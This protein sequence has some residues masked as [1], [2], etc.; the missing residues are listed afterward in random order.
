MSKVLKWLDNYWYHYKWQ[1]LIVIFVLVV[2]VIC[3]GQM[4]TRTTAD[5]YILYGGPAQLTANEIHE[6][7]LAIQLMMQQDYN[8]DGEK[9]AELIY[10]LL[11]TDQQRKDALSEAEAQSE[12]LIINAKN[13][14]DNQNAFA[15]QLAVGDAAICF[16]DP[17]WY[18]TARENNAFVP[19]ATLLGK[20]PENAQD[21]Y[22]ILLCDLPF[23]Q[24]FSA[25]SVFPPDTLVAVRAESAVNSSIGSDKKARLYEQQLEMFR[26]MVSF[27]VEN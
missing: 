26:S 18:Q 7:D 4:V 3:I 1:T 17:A 20:T 2:A 15:T 9:S 16:L 10:Y 22:S 19:L 5:V 25:F 14:T 12:P 13:L 24:Y 21:E 6:V 8:G 27:T 23:A 11:M